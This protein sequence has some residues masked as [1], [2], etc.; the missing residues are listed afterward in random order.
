MALDEGIHI[1]YYT[2]LT[3]I[4]PDINNVENILKQNKSVY[5]IGI[6]IA[7]E[8]GMDFF[9]EGNKRFDFKE[10]GTFPNEDWHGRALNKLIFMEKIYRIIDN[11]D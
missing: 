11:H 3:I 6:V 8:N 5:M 1:N 9:N 4:Q 2:N 7:Y 10:V